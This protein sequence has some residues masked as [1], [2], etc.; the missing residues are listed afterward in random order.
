MAVHTC[1]Q[2]RQV[3]GVVGVGAV[4]GVVVAQGVE[5]GGALTAVAVVDVEDKLREADKD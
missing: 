1:K 2:G 5:E 4:V 3:P